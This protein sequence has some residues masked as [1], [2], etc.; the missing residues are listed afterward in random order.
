MQRIAT[1]S[2]NPNVIR[3]LDRVFRH[4]WGHA[5]VLALGTN[6]FAPP[7][8]GPGNPVSEARIRN[9]PVRALTRASRGFP[10]YCASVAGGASHRS[11]VRRGAPCCAPRSLTPAPALLHLR[12]ADGAAAAQRR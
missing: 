1:Q 12:E 7:T 10:N 6:G 9:R 4:P 3:S 2:G 8:P 11:A 5:G